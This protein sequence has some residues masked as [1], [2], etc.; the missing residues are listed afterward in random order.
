MWNNIS[1]AINDKNDIFHIK[2]INRLLIGV[3][4][5]DVQQLKMHFILLVFDLSYT[6]CVILAITHINIE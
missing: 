5:G 4:Y 2:S 1:I 6:Y 3:S